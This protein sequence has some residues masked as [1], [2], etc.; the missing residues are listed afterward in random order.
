MST[1]ASPESGCRREQ[2]QG[3]PGAALLAM[4]LINGVA[5]WRWS[6]HRGGGY[7][8]IDKKSHCVIVDNNGVPVV[9]FDL[10]AALAN[11]L[12]AAAATAA[13]A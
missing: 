8:E 12:I 7:V 3:L 4:G 10:R 9:D 13:D 6:G 1:V 5:V 11:G 2:L